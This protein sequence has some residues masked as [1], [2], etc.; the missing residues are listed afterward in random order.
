MTKVFTVYFNFK[1]EETICEKELFFLGVAGNSDLDFSYFAQ[2]H[3]DMSIE[4]VLIEG[5]SLYIT[6][7]AKDVIT[8]AAVAPEGCSSNCK[9]KIKITNNGDTT[10]GKSILS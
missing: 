9:L 6:K 8:V 4:E 10:K 7:Q 5:I 1:D 3:E 2:E